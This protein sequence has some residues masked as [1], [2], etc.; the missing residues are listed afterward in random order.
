M[1][2]KATENTITS[3][4]KEELEKFGVKAEAFISISTPIGRREADLLCKNAGIYILEAKFT[5][6]TLLNAIAKIQNDYL[7]FY[8]FLNIKGGFA[9]LYPEELKKPMPIETIKSLIHKLKFKVVLIFPPKDTRNFSVKEGDLRVIAKILAEQI[10]TPPSYVE[11]SIDYM[12]KSLRD[13]AKYIINGLRHLSGSQLEGIFGGKSVFK[14]ILQY[15]K[16]EKYPVEDLRLAAAYLLVNQILFYHVLSRTIPDRFPEI[17]TDTLI[18]PAD[19]KYYFGKVLNVNYKTVFSYEV[20][21]WVPQSFINE[22][23][24]LV[25]VIKGLSPEKVRR[26]LLGTIFHDL[27]P[28]EIRKSVAAFYTNIL[29]A[30]LLANLSIDK[31]DVKVADF[32]CGSGGLLVAAY[33][34]K[35]ELLER[36]KAFTQEDHRK[37][38]EEDLLG[39]DVMPFAANI[40][41][42]HLALQSPEYLTNKVQIAIWDSTELKPGKKI[43]SIAKL[44]TVL[45]GQVGLDAFM[46]KKNRETKGVVILGEEKPSEIPLNKYD[47][48]IMNPP[49][50]RQ[51]RMPRE[52]KDRLFERFSE[53]KEY[54]ERRLGYYGYFILLADRFLNEGGRMALVL[55]ATILRIKTCEGLRK[56]WSKRYY[57]EYIITTSYRSAFSESVRF[58]EILLIAKKCIPSLESKTRIAILKKLPTTIEEAKELAIKLKNSQKDLEDDKVSVKMIEYKKLTSETENWFK[59]IAVSDLSLTNILEEILKSNKLIS[60]LSKFEAFLSNLYDY[61]YGDFHGFILQEKLRAL[62]KIDIWIVEKLFE[63]ELEIKHKILGIKRRIPL[64]ILGRGMR[65][66]S[67][68]TKI[69]VTENLDYLILSW[70]KEIKELAKFLLPDKLLKEFNRENI[71]TWKRNFQQKKTNLLL[72][73]R[74]DLSAPGT[75]LISFYSKIPMV[76]VDMWCIKNVPDEYAKILTLWFNSTLNL[77]QIFILRTETR[78]AWIKVHDYMLNELLVPD[79]EKLSESD[80]KVL[81]N[82]FIQVKDVKFPCIFDRLKTKFWAS[83]L[84]DKTWLQI[85]GY[86]SDVTQFLNKLYDFLANEIELLKRLMAEGTIEE[87]DMEE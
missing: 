79:Y 81:Q 29:A 25:N 32:A 40:A 41:A 9:L 49:F 20:V 3:L 28:L 36:K 42:C 18:K 39:I 7:K 43:P 51:E 2:P 68:I 46:K 14:N 77:L 48:I 52:Y 74:L 58:R 62:K 13:S 82:L 50:T 31:E 11:P 10:L 24:F 69:D 54:L 33:R 59:Y 78:G 8:E 19:L 34:R 5:E 30:E 45:T 56:L 16:E 44:E 21:S 66:P 71:E 73:R 64:S 61:K 55:P 23:K 17:D 15:E 12:I 63:N 35:K 4:L 85:L 87:G 53:Y 38:V 57:V 1:I 65:R 26:D 84:I 22:V 75:S 80:L 60:L 70:F 47:V 67:Y 76:G 86:K 37:F 27:V 6:D 72:S 83:F